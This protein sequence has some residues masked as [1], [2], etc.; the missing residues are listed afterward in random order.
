M[1]IE[2]IINNPFFV[3]VFLF[4]A[5]FWKGLALWKSSQKRQLLWFLILLVFN[6]LGILEILYVFWLNKWNLDQGRL[7]NFLEKKFKKW[8]K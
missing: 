2:E 6:T 8:R 7:L 5:L 1:K 4:W 3:S